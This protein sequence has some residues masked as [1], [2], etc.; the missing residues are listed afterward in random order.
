MTKLSLRNCKNCSKLPS[1][2][3]LP[4]L[5]H[6][7]IFQLDRLEKIG[8]EFYKNGESSSHEETPFRSLETLAFDT[9]HGLREWHIPHAFDG[10]RKLKSLEITECPVLTGNLPAKLPAL[11]QLSITQCEKLSCSLPREA[12][13][14]RLTVTGSHIHKVEEGA[15]I[16]FG[17]HLAK[18]VLE[19][20]LPHIQSSSLQRLIIRE[21]STLTFSE[22]LQHKW[23]TKIYVSKCDSMTLFPLGALPSLKKLDISDCSGMDSFGEEC[24][25]PSLTT[26]RINNCKKLESMIASK[27]LQSE[28]LTHLILEQWNE[29]K[30]FPPR[31]ACLPS[32]L[33]FIKLSH[34]SNL[35]TLDCE[36][37]HH[38]TSLQELRIKYCGKLDNITQERLPA[39]IEEIHIRGQCPLRRKLEKM[40]DPRIQFQT[41]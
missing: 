5:Q 34:F 4:S 13:L 32:S 9:M 37:L 11:E 28:G 8:P 29:V 27:G 21:C 36:R 40:N 2:G 14:H 1:L 24:L 33:H 15:A 22:P 10:F 39:S 17:T 35:E 25:P 19:K 41:D 3:Q 30:S 26:L 7:E 16:I 31:E 12:K 6:L 20:C 23:L 18:S 38:L